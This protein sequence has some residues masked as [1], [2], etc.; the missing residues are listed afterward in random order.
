MIARRAF[1][2]AIL[3]AV[4]CLN[5]AA[6]AQTYPSRPISIIVP[7]AAGGGNDVITRTVAQRLRV[8]LGQNVIV[9]NVTGANGSIGAP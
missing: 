1:T 8:V 6:L 2:L 7:F 5:V 3:A 9:E 4:S